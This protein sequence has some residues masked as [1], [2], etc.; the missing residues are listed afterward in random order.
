VSLPLTY[1]SV[2][3]RQAHLFVYC[4]QCAIMPNLSMYCTFL[5]Y[6]RPVLQPHGRKFVA[7]SMSRYTCFNVPSCQVH[8]SVY[9]TC[10]SYLRPVLQPHGSNV[11]ATRIQQRIVCISA[12]AGEHLTVGHVVVGAPVNL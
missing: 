7:R 1:V 3:S 12:I 11:P 4:C 5:T 2:P 9:C 8:L 10:P 6:L